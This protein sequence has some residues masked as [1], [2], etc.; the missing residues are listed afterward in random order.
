MNR[1]RFALFDYGFRPFFL[2]CG[3]FTVLAMCW[4]IHLYHGGRWMAGTLPG[5]LLHGHEMLFGFVGAA[6]GGFLL[7]AVP[8]WT[9]TQRISGR[10]LLLLVLA[11]LA[12][13]C[14]FAL[15][16]QLPWTVVV[17][18]ELLFVLLLLAAIAAPI[19]GGRSRALPMLLLL[20]AY[21]AADLVFLRALAAGDA[22]LAQSALRGA[23]GMVLLLLTIIGGRII[24]AFTANHLR[25]RGMDVVAAKRGVVEVV[26]VV[27]M[28]LYVVALVWMPTSQAVGLLA[29]AA[30]LAH[31]WRMA[32]WGGHRSLDTPIVW[33]LHLAYLWLPVGLA[34]HALDQLAGVSFA[35]YWMHALG[36]GAMGGMI[37]AVMTRAALGHTGRALVVSRFIVAAYVLHTVSVVLR[38]FGPTLLP[39]PYALV[40]TV[41][42]VAWVLAWLLFVIVYAPILLLPRV[43]GKPG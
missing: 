28:S 12:G 14:A 11:W 32:G 7:T 21:A 30:A 37:L 1:P 10:P 39:L 15:V 31:A 34:L 2:V 5:H 27:S 13:R 35:V 23:M 41:A 38:V 17:V 24:P 19:L 20:L 8:A 9:N 4:W 6:I 29:A 43:D 42:G 22:V 25:A 40:V 33:V 18:A 3:L 16:E 26:T 36:A